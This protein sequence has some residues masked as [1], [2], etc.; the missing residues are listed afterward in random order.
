MSDAHVGLT[1]ARV[2]IDSPLKSQSSS[3]HSQPCAQPIKAVI[4]LEL[5][6]TDRSAGAESPRSVMPVPGDGQPG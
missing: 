6:R 1:K 4:F 2:V 3:R 5:S